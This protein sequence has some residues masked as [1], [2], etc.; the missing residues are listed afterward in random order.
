MRRGRRHT[1][2]H[3][4]DPAFV[5]MLCDVN[6]LNVGPPAPAVVLSVDEKSQIQALDC[7]QTGLPAKTGAAR[8]DDDA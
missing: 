4:N 3:S 6:G 7:T 8:R 2:K 5:K 1:F